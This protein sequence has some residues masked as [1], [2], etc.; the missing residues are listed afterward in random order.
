MLRTVLIVTATLLAVSPAA[1]QSRLTLGQSVS[2]EL[3]ASDPSLDDGTHYD[4]FTVVAPAGQRVQVDMMSRDF[5]SYLLVGEGNCQRMSGIEQ[6]DDFGGGA[7]ARVVRESTGQ[8]LYIVANSVGAGATGAYTLRTSTEGGAAAGRPVGQASSPTRLNVG[9]AVNGML[10]ASDQRLPDNSFFDCYSVQTRAGHRLQIDQ[11]S[12]AFDSYLSVGT[13]SCEALT[14]TARDDDGG[15]NL[16]ARIVHDGDGRVLFIQANSVNAG[17]TGAYQLRVTSVDSGGASNAAKPSAYDTE[18]PR[19]LAASRPTTLPVVTS[20]WDTDLLTC[21]AAYSAMA[22]MMI[23][24]VH[25][26]EWG[27]V[28]Q[29]PWL[30]RRAALGLRIEYD[31]SNTAMLDVNTANFKS[32][33]LVGSIG[34]A[35]NGQPNQGRPLAEFLTALGNCDR[36]HNMT[37]VT[38]Y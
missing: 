8:P 11:T 15:G 34:V 30:N 23:E 13:G 25:P 16:N 20:D 4:C 19:S 36:A 7:D 5:D 6:N 14:A 28:A 29:I 3:S 17:E 24:N 38:R 35:P 9:E 18:D 21:Y 37:P 27:N 2:A 31:P 10:T 32:M 33:S 26:R 12:T 1:A 22:E